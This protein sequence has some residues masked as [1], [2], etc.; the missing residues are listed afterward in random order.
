MSA[1]DLKETVHEIKR[2]AEIVGVFSKYGLED[3]FDRT[4][5][6]KRFGVPMGLGPKHSRHGQTTAPEKLRLALEELGPAFVKLGQFLSTRPDILPFQYITELEK[7]QDAVP[8]VPYREVRV[9]IH[10][11]LG[12][13]V[14]Q[15]FRKFE[16][17]PVA[18][19]SIAQVHLAIL[20][21]GTKV[22]VKVRRPDIEGKITADTRI[23]SELAKFLKNR[24]F[25]DSLKHGKDVCS[26]PFR[27]TVKTMEVCETILA[28]ALLRKE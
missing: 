13:T 5:L 7:L 27:D 1:L 26:S 19:A 4:G 15:L 3:L 25:I 24:E 10:A 17:E 18:S 16:H 11:A 21:D 28:Q 22:A 2:T 12:R 20:A 9:L 14:D 23:I 6:T 8:P